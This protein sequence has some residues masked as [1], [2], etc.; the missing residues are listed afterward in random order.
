MLNRE[1]YFR[2]INNTTTVPQWQALIEK[3]LLTFEQ[4]RLL[5][6]KGK[7]LGLDNKNAQ[8]NEAYQ[9]FSDM[10]DAAYQSNGHQIQDEQN[11][12]EQADDNSVHML[13]DLFAQI[14]KKVS[15]T[16][17]R[18][19]MRAVSKLFKQMID[20]IPPT[21]PFLLFNQFQFLMKTL[22]EIPL[23]DQLSGVSLPQDDLKW[24][25]TYS[26]KKSEY[27]KIFLWVGI[28]IALLVLIPLDMAINNHNNLT[29]HRTFPTCPPAPRMRGGGGIPFKR[30]F[31][32]PDCGSAD[33]DNFI[34]IL[35]FGVAP[36]IALV[37]M[38][39]FL[40]LEADK[41]LFSYREKKKVENQA[42]GFLGLFSQPKKLQEI[43]VSAEESAPIVSEVKV[44]ELPQE[45]VELQKII[46]STESEASSESVDSESE[47]NSDEILLQ[48]RRPSK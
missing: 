20:D 37:I 3:P 40:G 18:V 15:S 9:F 42:I 7:T 47:E 45:E 5:R 43:I 22:P 48:K 28:F 23:K 29:S 33:K 24:L 30:G 34:N 35:I 17:D 4:C 38:F 32:T 11:N 44:M 25:I 21:E 13:P 12:S 31:I 26:S 36:N 6:N 1:T 2:D 8:H 10:L 16:Y 19:P 39:A 41:A 27:T 14:L 46:V